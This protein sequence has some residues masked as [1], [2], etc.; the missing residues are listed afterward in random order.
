MMY[1]RRISESRIHNIVLDNDH[2]DMV[3]GLVINVLKTK[4]SLCVQYEK[5]TYKVTQGQHAM[6]RISTDTIYSMM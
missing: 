4:M 3:A 1:D 5:R 6:P 2:G